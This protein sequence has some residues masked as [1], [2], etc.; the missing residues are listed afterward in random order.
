MGAYAAIAFGRIFNFRKILA[1]SPQYRIDQPFDQRWQNDARRIT[2]R[3]TMDAACCLQDGQIFIVYDPLHLDA[4]HVEK[5]KALLSAASLELLP[6]KYSA[7]PSTFWLDAAGVLKDLLGSV[8][9]RG[10]YGLNVR[11]LRMGNPVHLREVGKKLLVHKKYAWSVYWLEKSLACGG[12][13]MDTLGILSSAQALMGRS[14][15]A[16]AT[17]LSALEACQTDAQ[18]VGQLYH[19]T[20]LFRSLGRK[21]EAMEAVEQAIAIS[22]PHS[23]LVAERNSVVAMKV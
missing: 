8:F 19:L 1:L 3:Y 4:L 23:G 12:R 10:E 16:V 20:R 13:T 11:A 2:W 18:R 21:E 17:R 9:Q 14:D 22:P 5:M 15:A 6:L 7:H